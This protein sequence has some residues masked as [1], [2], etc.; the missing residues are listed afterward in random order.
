MMHLILI[1][2]RAC[3]KSSL[4]VR[5]SRLLNLPRIDTDRSVEE[6]T[7]KRIKDIFA[8][9]GEEQFRNYESAAL[10]HALEGPS[11][12]IATGGGI[13]ER[14][15]NRILLQEQSAVCWLFTELPVIAARLTG[16]LDRPSLTGQSVDREIYEVYQRREP[17]YRGAADWC[18][19][20]TSRPFSVIAEEIAEI[21][22]QRIAALNP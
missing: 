21:Y 13:V 6:L 8:E 19:D 20:T 1:G 22:R 10:R 5:C 9:E 16:D 4:A 17:L 3:G 14:E 7:G 12:V 18:A 11:A 2:Y 15:E